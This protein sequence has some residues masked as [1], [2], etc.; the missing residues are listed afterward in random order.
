MKKNEKPVVGQD[1]L[2]QEERE[3]IAWLQ[4]ASYEEIKTEMTA[5]E[6]EIFRT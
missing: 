2:T 5:V 6:A 4:S 1:G 3:M